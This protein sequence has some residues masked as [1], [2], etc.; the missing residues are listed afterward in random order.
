VPVF[1][2]YFTAYPTSL[3]FA[4]RPDV[5]GWDAEVLRR[6]DAETAGRA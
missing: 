5:Y 1:I 6:V 2:G 3:G 4:F